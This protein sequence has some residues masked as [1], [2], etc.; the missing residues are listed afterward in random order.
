MFRFLTI[1]ILLLCL[2]PFTDA[3]DRKKSKN[4]GK[5]KFRITEVRSWSG[6][7]NHPEDLG[8]VGQPLRRVSFSDYPDGSGD[9]IRA[10]ANPRR[11]SNLVV[12]QAGTLIPSANGLTDATWAW[13]QFIDHD[14][15]LSDSHPDNG[16]A[17]I[18]VL[19]PADLLYPTIFFN[20]ANHI[21]VDGVREQINEVTSF[22]D[23]SQIY[24]SDPIRAA[25]LRTFQNGKLKTSFGNL[26]P[27][28]VDG[29]PNLGSDPE[30]FL[31]GDIRANE[32][33]VLTCMHT[34]FVREH[35]RLAGRISEL[36]PAA[37]DEEIYHL[38]RK[39]VG[40]EIQMITYNEFLPALLGPLAPS[41]RSPRY[42]RDLDP[43]VANEFS[44][45]SIGSA[46]PCCPP[47]C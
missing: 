45:C 2:T 25:A 18:E 12:D 8:A 23:G 28:N 29:L 24:G 11:V 14:L 46:T 30:L 1:S 4:K 33:V 40:A 38:S 20:R 44:G 35:N 41:H 19:N 15:D 16:A 39:I 9:A 34:L 31:A 5:D 17:N 37:G 10:G 27:L 21:Y 6:V 42:N 3:D 47:I 13:G 43:S 22:L 32:N 26:L 36:A 7:D